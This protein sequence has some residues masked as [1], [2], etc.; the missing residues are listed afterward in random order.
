MVARH[1]GTIVVVVAAGIVPNY[2]GWG[3]A[4]GGPVALSSR[5]ATL[6]LPSP[7]VASRSKAGVGHRGATGEVDEET[8]SGTKGVWTER[9]A[10]GSAADCGTREG[11]GGS[12]LRTGIGKAGVSGGTE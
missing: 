4:E 7:P 10:A 1:L 11:F 6:A 12:S 3:S 5:K 9:D 2:P 8:V